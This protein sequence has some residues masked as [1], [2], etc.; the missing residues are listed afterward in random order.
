ME[1]S[2]L[3]LLINHYLQSPRKTK[4]DYFVYIK[5]KQICNQIRLMSEKNKNLHIKKIYASNMFL[6]FGFKEFKSNFR[7]APERYFQF[8]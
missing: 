1:Q 2:L 4:K 6:V 3:K 5:I 7:M 8:H